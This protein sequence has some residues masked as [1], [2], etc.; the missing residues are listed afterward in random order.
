MRFSV[1]CVCASVALV[2]PAASEEGELDTADLVY[3]EADLATAEGARETLKSFRDQAA[4]ACEIRDAYGRSV[5]RDCLQDML[6][7]AVD[8][9]NNPV[10]NAVYEGTKLNLRLASK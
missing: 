8:Q 10:L 3:S 4:A 7:S 9:I 6:G 5:D 2:A 1:L